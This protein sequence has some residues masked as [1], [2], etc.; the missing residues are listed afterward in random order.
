MKEHPFFDGNKV[1]TLEFVQPPPV[2]VYIP[3]ADALM[4]L[5]DNVYNRY[6]FV[7]PFILYGCQYNRFIK[8]LN[9]VLVRVMTD[10]TVY[11]NV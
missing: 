10:D 8:T 7:L 6:K 4:Q 3:N 5:H 2:H 9:R 11:F 1:S